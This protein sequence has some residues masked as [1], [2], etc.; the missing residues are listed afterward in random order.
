MG[1]E[2][3]A[4]LGA[5]LGVAGG[6]LG[7]RAGTEDPVV[8]GD[9]E[10]L[11]DA[12]VAQRLRGVEHLQCGRPPKARHVKHAVFEGALPAHETGRRVGHRIKVC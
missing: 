6:E 4:H 9:A 2:K 1:Q 7:A 11:E 5:E 8:C 12:E 10:R 3:G